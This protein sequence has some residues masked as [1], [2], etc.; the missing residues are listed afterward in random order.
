M[1]I[2]MLVE[3]ASSEFSRSSLMALEGRWMIW[4]LACTRYRD[5][6]GDEGVEVGHRV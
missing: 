1:V 3:P 2:L 6:V 5:S 4:A